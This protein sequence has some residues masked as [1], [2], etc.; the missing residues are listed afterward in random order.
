MHSLT[1]S[2]RTALE[3]LSARTTLPAPSR[4]AVKLAWIYL[5]WIQRRASRV[6]LADLDDHMLRDIGLTVRDAMH[7]ARKPFWRP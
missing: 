5:V 4:F 2:D 7:E 1:R 3:A 6:R